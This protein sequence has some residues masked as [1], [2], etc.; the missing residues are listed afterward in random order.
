VPEVL[1]QSRCVVAII[2]ELTRRRHEPRGWHAVPAHT[3]DA[4]RPPGRGDFLVSNLTRQP[5]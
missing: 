3:P 1:L 2:G 5:G 4:R